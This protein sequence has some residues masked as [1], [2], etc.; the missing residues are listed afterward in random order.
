M[1][2]TALFAEAFPCYPDIRHSHLDDAAVP[3]HLP[4]AVFFQA[5]LAQNLVEVGKPVWVVWM[6]LVPATPQYL[7]LCIRQGKTGWDCVR[8]HLQ[9]DVCRGK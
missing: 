2:K 4:V 8:I 5:L 3:H 9:F 1:A 6:S 7:F